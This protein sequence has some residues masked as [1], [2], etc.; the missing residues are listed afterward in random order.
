MTT[1]RRARLVPPRYGTPRNP[2]RETRGGD[3]ALVAE[4]LR[5]TP[6]PWQQHVADVLGEIDPDTG[7]LFYSEGVITVPR[8]SGKTTLVVVKAVKRLTVDA[9]RL[10][11]QRVTYTAQDRN[12]ARRKLE[13]DFAPMLRASHSFP[14]VPSSSRQRPQRSTGWKMTLAN[15]QE[16]ILFGSGSYWQ[17]DTPSATAGHGD[18]LDEGIIDEAFAHDDDGVE[19]SMRPAQATRRD[20]QL[21]V[22]S[23]VGDDKS[24]YLWAKC[25]AG[26]AAVRAGAES[27]T[28]YFEWSLPGGPSE[29]DDTGRPLPF[30]DID[31]EAL[32]WEHFPAL[33]HTQT[34][35]FLR[36][37]LDRA[38]RN[39]ERGEAFWLRAYGNVWT[40]LPPSAVAGGVWPEAT[41]EA[42]VSPGA[43]PSGALYFG[44]AADVGQ[45]WASIAFAGAGVVELAEHARGVGWLLPRL[46]QIRERDMAARQAP[47]ALDPAGPAA[48]LMPDLEAAGVEVVKVG[49]QTMRSACAAFFVAVRDGTVRIRRHPDLDAAAAAARRHETGD[50]WVWARR[51][52]TID[53]SPLEAVT[54]AL[55][56][57]A[58]APQPKKASTWVIGPGGRA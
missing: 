32:W 47:V 54:C 44:L 16:H 6:M 24:P 14:E 11:R 5:I 51:D 38:R 9:R 26:R 49:G 17:I 7:D 8:Q 50:G 39:P 25:A 35:S 4:R 56:A 31:D 28:A 12:M 27:R 58:S 48:F 10:G 15:G 57:S 3:F 18:T 34:P 20:A 45:S 33:G 55:W 19:Q 42:V 37:E 29:L 53:V 46:L 30:P 21:N 1:G 23:T 43:A 52:G 22:L 41:W 36:A 2:D 40:K 13:R